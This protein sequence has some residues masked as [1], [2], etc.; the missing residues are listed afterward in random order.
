MATSNLFLAT[1]RLFG[2]GLAGKACLFCKYLV[3]FVLQRPIN[4]VVYGL[5]ESVSG[6]VSDGSP[7][8]CGSSLEIILYLASSQAPK[9][10]SLHRLEQKGKNVACLDCS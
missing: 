3:S 4:A 5:S 1:E 8:S 10:I 7:D 2:G 9:S 6:K